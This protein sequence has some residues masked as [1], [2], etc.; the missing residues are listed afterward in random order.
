M[1][2]IAA[3]AQ[4]IA[5]GRAYVKAHPDDDDAARLLLQLEKELDDLTLE[6]VAPLLER[7]GGHVVAIRDVA[8]SWENQP[9]V[10]IETV[11]STDPSR[12]R[13]RLKG[14]GHKRCP[15]GH[16]CDQAPDGSVIC[17]GQPRNVEEVKVKRRKAVHSV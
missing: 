6:A 1:D 17:C 11:R 3:L 5:N 4:R 13:P 8:G 2:E 14:G 16:V 12:S 10:R 15:A 7:L 9:R